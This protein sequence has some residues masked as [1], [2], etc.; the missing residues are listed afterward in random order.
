MKAR[1]IE[2]HRI[3]LHDALGIGAPI[4]EETHYLRLIDFVDGIHD[5]VASDPIQPCNPASDSVNC[6]ASVINGTR[7]R[8][9][10]SSA[11]SSPIVLMFNTCTA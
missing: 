8:A 1:D 11:D 9:T 7:S 3:A 5:K 4:V 2:S 10:T 6:R